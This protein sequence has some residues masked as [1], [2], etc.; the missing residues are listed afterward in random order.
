MPFALLLV[1]LVLLISGV[2]NTQ[3]TLFATVKGDFTGQD[4]FIYWFAAIIIIGAVGY[5]PKLK[6]ISTA[7]LALVIIVL[8]LKKGSASGVGGGLFAQLT[9]ALNSTGTAQAGSTSGS[10]LQAQMTAAQNQQQN[11]MGQLAQNLA[12]DPVTQELSQ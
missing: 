1:G 3:D 12:T 9:S 7:F 11:L 8:F 4:N 2:K 10:N 6:P 5:V